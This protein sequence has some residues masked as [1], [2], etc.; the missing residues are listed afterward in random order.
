MRARSKIYHID[1]FRCVGCSR[2]LI[3][4]DEFALRDDG[5]FCKADHDVLERSDG[6]SPDSNGKYYQ[7]FFGQIWKIYPQTLVY[8]KNR[9]HRYNLQKSPF[10]PPLNHPVTHTHNR[11][12]NFM[13]Q[14]TIIL[15]PKRT[16]SVVPKIVLNPF[17]T[18]ILTIINICF[19]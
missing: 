9:I 11:D 1:C 12:T 6:D 14:Y 16:M 4:G 18:F 19:I 17:K 2:Q 15:F 5:L 13:N 8:T 10:L 3:P 7:H